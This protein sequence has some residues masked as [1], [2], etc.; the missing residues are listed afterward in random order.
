MRDNLDLF[1]ENVE[2]MCKKDYLKFF[3]E[4]NELLEKFSEWYLS[5]PCEQQL[6]AADKMEQMGKEAGKSIKYLI[7][8]FLLKMT[9]K[10]KY[11]KAI[12]E[13]AMDDKELTKENKYFIYYQLSGEN[14]QNTGPIDMELKILIYQFYHQ[15]YSEY[16]WQFKEELRELPQESRNSDVVIVFISQFLTMEHGPTKTA[17]DRCY[18]LAKT[19]KKKVWL[20]NTAEFM[21][22]VGY[23]PIFRG[24]MAN[25]RQ[26]WCE[27]TEIE[28]KG[29]VF[30][31]FQ[32]VNYMPNDGEIKNIIHF[33]KKVSPWRIF[34]IGGGSMVMDLCDKLVPGMVVNTVHSHL[35]CTES[36]Y[37]LIGRKL[38]QEDEQLFKHLGKPL[39]HVIECRFTFALREQEH[40]YTRED[41]GI[42]KEKFVVLIV[43]AR[44]DEEIKEEFVRLLNSLMEH[45]I[46]VVF[47]GS[48]DKYKDWCEKE[49]VW[50]GNSRYLG[51]MA[52]VL[53]VNE[54]CDLY[55]NPIRNGG[56]TSVVEAFY[57]G[58]PAV[59][60]PVGDVF[61][62]AGD[63]FTVENYEEMERITLKY[64]T[65]KVF[66]QEQ[67][68]KAK[69]RA[70]Y[71]MDSEGIFPEAIKEMEYRQ[72]QYKR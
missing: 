50:R 14:F 51:F 15:V 62:G 69:E 66:Y 33:V 32:C 21:S 40:I 17:L 12:Y 35:S 63:N 72:K 10:K 4:I 16:F 34:H 65:D 41:L 1:W 7:F 61:L 47:M 23:F 59:T 60:C 58:L 68:Q 56:G 11:C 45:G 57:K 13:M 18:V 29:E 19:L 27:K 22:S 8:T 2:S 46:F 55:L 28:Y 64:A 49:A 6:Q 52:D 36:A 24:S 70:R 54:C 26:D 44:L 31:F 71:L 39:S 43:G 20:I 53:A 42:P 37:Q 9:K 30:H 48:F 67:S 38:T 25:Y 5:L 3:N